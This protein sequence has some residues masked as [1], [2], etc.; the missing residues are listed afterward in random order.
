ML[1]RAQTSIKRPSPSE[2]ITGKKH[3]RL[4][5]PGVWKGKARPPFW[6]R[7]LIEPLL[8]LSNLFLLLDLEKNGKTPYS[9][10]RCGSINI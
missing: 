7:L 4:E 1:S 3:Q 10:L 6:S 9:C 5:F 8:R 2:S